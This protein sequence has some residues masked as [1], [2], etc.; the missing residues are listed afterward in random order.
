MRIG[1]RP[2]ST[3]ALIVGVLGMVSIPV[4]AALWTGISNVNFRIR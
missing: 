4:S 3:L 2:D 1:L